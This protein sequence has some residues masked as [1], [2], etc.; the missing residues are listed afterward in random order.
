[1][2][3]KVTTCLSQQTCYFGRQHYNSYS[4]AKHFTF[5]PHAPPPK[6]KKIGEGA[7]FV[8]YSY[9]TG[10]VCRGGGIVSRAVER[11]IF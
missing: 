2:S 6:E 5:Q 8:A 9:V 4:T 7:H 11:L 3:Q 10:R 1:M